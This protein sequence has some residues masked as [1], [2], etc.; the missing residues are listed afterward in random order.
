MFEEEPNPED[1]VTATDPS[2]KPKGHKRPISMCKKLSQEEIDEIIDSLGSKRSV[3]IT[4]YGIGF[5][6]GE[7]ILSNH[8][9][10]KCVYNGRDHTSSELAY[11]AECASAAKDSEAFRAIMIT[12]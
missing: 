6:T 8:Y 1:M 5:Y 2:T 7:C 4:K 3:Q 11:F 12:N 9:E 10:V